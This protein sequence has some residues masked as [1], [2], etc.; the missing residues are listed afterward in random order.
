[1]NGDSGLEASPAFS[2][3]HYAK[4]ILCEVLIIPP[5]G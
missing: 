2:Q 4:D 5:G 1:M 3:V